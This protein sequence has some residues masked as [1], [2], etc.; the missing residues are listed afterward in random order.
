MKCFVA[1][2][3]PIGCTFDGSSAKDGNPGSLSDLLGAEVMNLLD[4]VPLGMAVE[5]D[6]GSLVDALV[7][8]AALAARILRRS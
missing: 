5:A 8:G 3:D 1:G 4:C 2:C 7:L 6:K